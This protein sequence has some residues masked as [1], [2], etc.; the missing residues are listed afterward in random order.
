MSVS[1]TPTSTEFRM[2]S[3]ALLAAA[4]ERT[5]KG[6]LTTAAKRARNE[7]DRRD[8]KR[9]AKVAPVASSAPVAEPVVTDAQVDALLAEA[10]KVALAIAESLAITEAAEN[11]GGYV[12]ALIRNRKV[13]LA[14]ATADPAGFLV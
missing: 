4:M 8:A 3:D 14:A 7:I 13:Q 1:T 12:K 5:A 2:G 11:G 6:N 10:R 9:A